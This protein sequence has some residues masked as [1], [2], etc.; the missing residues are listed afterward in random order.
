MPELSPPLVHA[1]LS[2]VD[3]ITV[4]FAERRAADEVR[5]ADFII[6]TEGGSEVAVE[7]VRPKFARDGRAKTYGVRSAS[8]LD[9]ARHRYRIRAEGRG[10]A[11]VC[12]G[13]L[14]S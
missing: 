1:E 2:A 8:E 5:A 11:G 6:I 12:L 10:E 9:F 3:E 7:A 13:P 4:R 14:L